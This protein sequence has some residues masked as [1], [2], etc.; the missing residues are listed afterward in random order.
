MKKSW[1]RTFFVGLAV[2][3]SGGAAVSMFVAWLTVYA[4][5]D[6]VAFM[7]RIGNCSDFDMYD[8][9][10]GNGRKWMGWWFWY[11]CGAVYGEYT[12]DYQYETP[13]VSRPRN[14][15]VRQPL[16]RLPL[17][18]RAR[19]PPTGREPDFVNIYEV[20]AGWPF[21]AWYGAYEETSYEAHLK[22]LYTHS[23]KAFILPPPGR[24]V[25]CIPVKY[26]VMQM[27]GIAENCLLILPFRPLFPEALWS[28]LLYA[29]GLVLVTFPL[30]LLRAHLRR[31]RYRLGLCS[32]C[33]YEL[34]GLGVCPECG[35]ATAGGGASPNNGGVPGRA[36]AS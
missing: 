18:S 31:R 27:P 29:G 28:T 25:W 17:W 14:S 1:Y 5:T 30:T 7:N 33:G 23:R 11:R 20:A 10:E 22:K 4:V 8:G 3:L 15:Y 13:G 19:T 34:A 6:H 35:T 36:N 21:T 26:G 32:R 16:D 2:Y 9:A 12:R 24:A